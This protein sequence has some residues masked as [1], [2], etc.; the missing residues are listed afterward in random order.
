[1]ILFFYLRI[2]LKWKGSGSASYRLP[3]QHNGNKIDMPY[4]TYRQKEL[5]SSH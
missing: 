2:V 1:M 4:I 3:W 5:G